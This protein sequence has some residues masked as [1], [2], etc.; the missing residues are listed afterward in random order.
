[1]ISRTR[2]ILLVNPWIIDFAAYDFWIKPLG[3]L[4]IGALLR[5]WGIAVDLLDCLD[6]RHPALDAWQGC[7]PADHPDGSG[8]FI[9]QIA[10]KPACLQDVP[11]HYSRYGLPVEI[12]EKLLAE[13]EPPD[14]IFLTSMMTYWYP[15]VAEMAQ[16]LRRFFPTSP[17]VLG[18]V[19][20]TLLPEHACQ[21]V[22]PD[23]LVKG[24]A[25]PQLP[26]IVGR[27]F[28]SNVQPAPEFAALPF[29]AYDL[30]PQLD[31]IAI[32][33]SRG[34]PYSCSFCASH[35]LVQKFRQRHPESVVEELTHWVQNAGIR[36]AAF[37]DD[38][39]LV[40]REQSIKPILRRIIN[41]RLPVHLHL[42]NG[43][44]P[45]QIDRELADLLFAARADTIR[46]S[47]ESSRPERQADISGK[48]TPHDLEAALHLLQKAGYQRDKLGVYV[49][50]GL[51][52]Q[53]PEEVRESCL[54]VHELGARI[55]AASF[56]PIPGTRS[57]SLAVA[58]QE[59]ED[60]RDPLLS[61]SSLFPLW[62]SLYGYEFCQ[63]LLL[64][65]K[66]LN[67][68]I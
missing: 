4:R 6:R 44:Q 5:E 47:F 40:H 17:I 63:E 45:R 25:E 55:C 49:L 7:R 39:L 53:S 12:V 38:A 61:N 50:F 46:L 37:Y 62:R 60:H 9:R 30:Y 67:Q 1:M 27:L 29:P 2:R 41:D 8:K 59:W 11:R 48:V 35:L 14:A 64:W 28:G 3:L 57:W 54:L 18:G 33:T 43:I 24:E 68:S 26:A 20:A 15:A 58:K 31:S 13:I 36:H 10:Q 66:T 21:Q 32:E 22:Q 16:L 56:S 51:P 19:Y 65:I 34:C 42:P 23:L 52:E